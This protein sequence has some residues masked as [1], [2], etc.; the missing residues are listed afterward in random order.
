[1]IQV[2]FA[3]D[4]GLVLNKLRGLL[5]WETL[6]YQ[7]VGQASDGQSAIDQVGRLQP[8]LLILD[9]EMPKKNG[10]EVVR[11]LCQQQPQLDVLMLSNHDSFE[12]VRQAMRHGARDYLLKHQLTKD[13]LLRKLKELDEH[14]RIAT[15]SEDSRQ[16]FAT[17]AKQK[18]L[19]SLV[20]GEKL[21]LEQLRR[22]LSQP[23]FA[24]RCSVLA[25][26]QISNFISF[27]H[28]DG[29]QGRKR[30]IE[31]VMNLAE[32]IFSTIQ[33]G[34]I[35]HVEY[36]RFALLFNF[37]GEVS[38][39]KI[40]TQ[41][42]TYMRLI[43]SNLQKLLGITLIFQISDLISNLA[44]LQPCF[45]KVC[46]QLDTRALGE[47]V[48]SGTREEPVLSLL[49]EKKLMDALLALDYAQTMVLV[50]ALYARNINQ[51]DI[52][53]ERLTAAL[54]QVGER[55]A[56]AQQLL[57]DTDTVNTM[58]K[59]FTQQNNP[60]TVPEVICQYLQLL[61]NQALAASR[62]EYSVNIRQAAQIVHTHYAQDLPLPVVAQRLGISEA[63]LSRQFKKETGRSFVD[64]LTD[65]RIQAAQQLLREG[66]ELKEVA[67]RSGFRS[68]NYFLRVFKEKTGHTPT[69][70]Q[71]LK[72][73]DT[74]ES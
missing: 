62:P 33:R 17:M 58:Q 59:L 20:T 29:D 63:H 31:S 36:G 30:L 12:Y 35:A 46:H 44:Q 68:Y 66:F 28:F 45:Q 21:E 2:F 72:K 39:Q 64:C 10:V 32:N 55:F 18:H 67:A 70:L 7:I 26:M 50:Q 22:M 9:I 48:R 52:A 41:T 60:L 3:D 27:T 73:G 57:L 37:E 69:E 23:E 43:A 74:G 34:L 15:I 53:R 11:D 38:S 6:G 13:L 14:R 51:S 54:L 71:Q 47:G 24:S 1:M 40:A 5:D 25:V 19:Y 16:Y 49:G 56:T 42:A 61:I 65:Q 8:Q 4:D